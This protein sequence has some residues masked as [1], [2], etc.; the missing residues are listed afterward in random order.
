V[1]A[2]C[3]TPPTFDVQ[4]PLMSLPALQGATPGMICR[5]TP[6]LSPEPAAVAA[7]RRELA[8]Q[9]GF[10]I[11]IS[12]RGNPVNASDRRRSFGLAELAPLAAVDGVR[13]V[14]LQVG[15]GS[16]ELADVANYW[17]VVDIGCRIHDLDEM[18]AVMRSC[19]VVVTCDSAPAHLAGAVGVPVWIA[20]P[21]A[22]DWRWMFDRD[23]SPWYPTARLFRQSSPGDWPGV[24]RRVA[25]ALAALV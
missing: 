16:A 12:W 18:A 4:A 3:D 21:F 9:P 2:V 23:D 11:G 19:E 7:W 25:A 6:Y 14:S 8:T 17:P 13:L 5:D 20:L 24:F 1:I 15:P 22:A 10:K